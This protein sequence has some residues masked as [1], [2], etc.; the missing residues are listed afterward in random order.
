MR[1]AWHAPE[2]ESSLHAFFRLRTQVAHLCDVVR[3]RNRDAQ[4]MR[5]QR[6]A[7]AVDRVVGGAL[8]LAVLVR[9]AIAIADTVPRRARD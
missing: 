4:R 3:L 7:D 6:G 9:V 8:V 5:N 1:R 2:E